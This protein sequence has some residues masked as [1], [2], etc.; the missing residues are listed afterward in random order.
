MKIF[1]QKKNTNVFSTILNAL[2]IKYTDEY[3]NKLFNEHPHKY[4]LFGLSKMLSEY[5]IANGAIKLDDKQVSV[6]ELETPFIAHIGSDFV[7]VRKIEDNKV[8]YIWQSKNITSTI[9]EFCNIWTGVTLIAEPDEKSTEP[10]YKEHR[11]KVLFSQLQSGTIVGA[12]CLLLILAFFVNKIYA[13]IGICLLIIINLIGVYIGYLLVIK[14]MHVQSNYADKICS[15]FKKS[16]C[17]DILESEVAKLGGVLGWSEIGLG[18]F[19]TNIFILFFIPSLLPYLTLINICALP[20]SFWSIWYQK[21]RAKQWCPLCLI[22]QALLWSMFFISLTFG[23]IHLPNWSLIDILTIGCLYI[24]PIFAINLLIPKLSERQKLEKM[25]Q[26]LNSIKATDEVFISSLKKQPYYEIN[27]NTS[28]ILWGNADAQILVSVLTNPHCNPC[29]KM[30]QRIE[31]VLEETNNLCI[32]YIFSSFNQDLDVSNE[33]LTAI[34][35]N[36]NEQDRKIIYNNWFE[37][38]KFNK[39]EY[40]DQYKMNIDNNQIQEELAKHR[41]WKSKSGLQA[42]PTILVNG[43]KLPDN[44]K[45]EDLKYFIKLD[46]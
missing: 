43:Y 33:F 26:E 31:K 46:L 5:Q 9:D 42:T 32:Q 30:H 29:A 18:Y 1:S 2:G 12:S 41:A 13:D 45:I 28:M 36:K 3:A 15:L 22:V 14:Q 40:F 38:G 6:Y 8:N 21:F 37:Y 23:F 39:E 44:Y 19:L 10:Q 7:V 11:Q 4:N 16:D 25:T 27:K 34:Y 17:N 24:I 20:Y 35:F